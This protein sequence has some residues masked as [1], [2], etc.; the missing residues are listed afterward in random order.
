M[1]LLELF[2][3]GFL[4]MASGANAYGGGWSNA[5]ATFYG[6]SDASG[7]MGMLPK[8]WKNQFHFS[9]SACVLVWVN[10]KFWKLN[11]W[12]VRV[13]ESLQP[14]LRYKHRSSEYRFI[15]QRSQLRL[16]LRDSLRRREAVVPPRLDSGDGDQFLPPKQRLT[17]QCRRVVQ[18]SP[19]TLRPLAARLPTHC[20]V[21]SRHCPRCLQKVTI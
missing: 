19:P 18:P 3:V 21:Q 5:H 12:R 14:G 17:E 1:A 6:G 9:V 13:R 2:F 15:Q 7:T 16:L 11:R 4:A 8:N 20:S 10:S